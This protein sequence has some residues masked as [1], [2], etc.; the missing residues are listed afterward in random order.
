MT[1]TRKHRTLDK[2]GDTC[3][4]GVMMHVDVTKGFA[5]KTTK[6]CLAEPFGVTKSQGK[7][8]TVGF[9]CTGDAVE[10][11]EAEKLRRG[12]TRA[13]EQSAKRDGRE[14]ADFTWPNCT[15]FAHLTFFIGTLAIGRPSVPCNFGPRDPRY[16]A[17]ENY[18]VSFLH[19]DVI[20]WQ[21]INDGRRN[22]KEKN[23]RRSS[24][25]NVKNNRLYF[26]SRYFVG[27]TWTHH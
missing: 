4:E 21:L 23:S 19:C 11:K 10:R 17:Y 18:G 14:T 3:E 5:S 15:R 8:G 22:C 25:F 16:V 12:E 7:H 24:E 9:K 1:I 26:H 27:R 13:R 20:T 6:A 2:A